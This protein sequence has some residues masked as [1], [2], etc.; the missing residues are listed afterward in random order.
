M[1]SLAFCIHFTLIMGQANFKHK[2]LLY[3]EYDI[4]ICTLWVS[5]S[6]FF[7]LACFQDNIWMSIQDAAKDKASFWKSLSPCLVPHERGGS[8]LQGPVLS[9]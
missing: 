5:T 9:G 1:I 3:L 7:S 8:F 4:H 2:F 6:G